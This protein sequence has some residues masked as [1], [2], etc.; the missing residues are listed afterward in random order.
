MKLLLVG[1][2]KMGRMVESIAAEYECEIAGVLDPA[3]SAHGGGADAARWS[4]VE[5]AVDFSTPDSV[6]VNVPAL[7]KRGI[8]LVVGTTGWSAHEPAVR[9]AVADSGAGIV[10]APNFSIGMVLFDA[11]VAHA[12]QLFAAQPEFGAFIHEAHHATKKDAPSGTALL[13]QR[14]M[15]QAGFTRPIDTSS[16]RA[17]FIP[18]T[19]TIGFDGPAEAITLSHSSRDR[20]AFARGALTAAKWIH[21]RRGW[22]TMRDVLGLTEV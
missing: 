3:S 22:Y 17:G 21:G 9:R 18:G 12:A 8:N 1:H 15:Q 11:L 19:H 14:S 2:G 13:L 7:A 6:P 16:T 4:G 20:T 5:V 10:V